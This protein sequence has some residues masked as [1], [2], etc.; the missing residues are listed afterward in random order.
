MRSRATFNLTEFEQTTSP[1]LPEPW[2]VLP[3]EEG[4]HLK[5]LQINH[6]HPVE[7]GDI[8]VVFNLEPY[9]VLTDDYGLAYRF[10]ITLTRFARD[11][12]WSKVHLQ[13]QADVLLIVLRNQDDGL[14]EPDLRSTRARVARGQKKKRHTQFDPHHTN[15]QASRAS[16]K[17][18]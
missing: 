12:P 8:R 4:L 17:Q 18:R 13:G 10:C 9:R 16:T 6:R 7:P 14:R 5:I 15:R 2:L 1:Q 11:G 3:A